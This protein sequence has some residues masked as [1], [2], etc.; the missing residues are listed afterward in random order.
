[1]T[2]LR[3]LFGK[4]PINLEKYERMPCDLCDGSGLFGDAAG[5]HGNPSRRCPRCHGK[6]WLLV[7][8]GA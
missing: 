6:G 4:K 3:R 2:F 8:K 1:M 5:A 7:K